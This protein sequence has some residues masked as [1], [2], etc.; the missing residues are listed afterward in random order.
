MMLVTMPNE[1]EERIARANAAIEKKKIAAEA[2]AVRR[3]QKKHDDAVAKEAAIAAG[4][5]VAPVKK[6]GIRARCE[7]AEAA[8]AR[9][10]ERLAASQ[11]QASS[12]EE[13]A[14]LCGEVGLED[15]NV[16]TS[17]V[18]MKLATFIP[19]D[20]PLRRLMATCALDVNTIVAQ[21]YAFA[22]FHVTRMMESGKHVDDV[23]PNF[24]N[25]C[26]AAVSL[27]KVRDSTL[28]EDFLRSIDA[29]DALRPDAPPPVP[30]K[31]RAKGTRLRSRSQKRRAQKALVARPAAKV[32]STLLGDIKSELCIG[33][34]TMAANHLWMNLR[35]RIVK[36]LAWSQPDISKALRG[37]IADM[38][39]KCPKKSIANV[40]QLSLKT[41]K[42]KTISE[43]RRSAVSK[44]IVLTNE[45]RAR[46]PIGSVGAA[47]KA[48]LLLPLY[49][50]IMKETEEK[51]HHYRN[52]RAKGPVETKLAWKVNK[53]RFSILPLK[54]GFTIGYVPVCSRALVG[55]VRR[56]K[57][58]DGTP[59]ERFTANKLTPKE[60]DKLW[61][62]YCS[63]NKV[64]TATRVFGGRIST[65][66]VT[67]SI[68]ISRTQAFVQASE[69]E[70]FDASTIPDEV[71]HA[72]VDP[73]LTDVVTVAHRSTGK[74]VSYSSSRY[75]EAAKIKLSNRR[76]TT[77]N[78]ETKHFTDQIDSAVDK[79]S[80]EG[81][82]SN[83]R[84]YLSV[85]GDLLAHRAEQG[86]R[87][88][89]F[90]RYRFKQKAV[91]A[92]CDLIAPTGKFT[93][94]G[95]G[96]W[97]GPGN[98]PI[99]RRFC[100]PLQDI[101]RELR[102]RGQGDAPTVLFRSVWEYRTSV[103]CHA[104]WCR[105]VN[106][107]AVS[108]TYDRKE[109][110][111]VERPR[112]RIHKLLHCKRSEGAFGHH[113]GTW[114]RDANAARNILMLLML[115]VRGF[116]RP[117]EFMPAQLSARRVAKGKKLVEG[118]SPSQCHALSPDSQEVGNISKS[119]TVEMS[120]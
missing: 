46:C 110:R 27:C 66:G 112:Q 58:A 104:T 10:R 8:A 83:L 50:H 52:L 73:G 25:R 55:M 37:V 70:P 102:R 87:N 36:W 85:L 23:G 77:W 82:S 76:T 79:S 60:H 4:T 9:H 89:R 107:R 105:L 63:V 31:R 39:S 1:L 5:Y 38:V 15:T 88:M 13:D 44:A 29:F 12:E 115:E 54:H 106:A 62:K 17:C 32:D 6:K 65:D 120:H 48:H 94:V 96:D 114:N 47:N 111:M 75:Y 20:A 14:I 56:L 108:V 45:L 68:H 49:L 26:L 100:G 21:A 64:E 24:Y 43:A 81:L 99:R 93:V 69:T 80:L 35:S 59:R 2:T 28:D 103:T 33:M 34:A 118:G 72:G 18:K 3:A 84:S 116:Q 61:R 42:G 67:V 109:N 19:D 51:V 92:I 71:E 86:Y 57:G 11:E 30:M 22:N 119:T 91:L 53:T 7:A 41:P 101:K 90:L 98:T 78:E 40:K 95:F 117:S 74:V 97:A 113:G 16:T